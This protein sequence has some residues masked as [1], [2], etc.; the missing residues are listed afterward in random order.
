MPLVR[1]STDVGNVASIRVLEK[2][3]ARFDRRDTVGC[4]DTVFYELPA[5]SRF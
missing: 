1:A 2:L 5:S 4:L 3:G